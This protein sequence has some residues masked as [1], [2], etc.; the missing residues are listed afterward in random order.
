MTPEEVEQVLL[1]I[2]SELKP[3]ET[4]MVAPLP[5]EELSPIPIEELI[6]ELEEESGLIF[7][8]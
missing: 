8:I 1:E 4:L 6:S 5:E 7:N 2:S 3:G